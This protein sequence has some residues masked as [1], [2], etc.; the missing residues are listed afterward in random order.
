MLQFTKEI[1]YSIQFISALKKLKEKELLSL[2]NFSKQEKISFLFLQRIVKKLREAG[3]VESTKGAC[4]GYK[5]AIDYKD[6][7]VKQIIEALEGE[8]AVI[9][10]LKENC[11]CKKTGKCF[12]Q[13]VFKKINNQL[14][15]Y[16][17]DLKLKDVE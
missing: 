11:Q 16:L 4:G 9:D 17:K 1:D 10:C 15:K 7:N 13:K 5:L 3:L 8:Y 14:I 12:S 2:H 6:I